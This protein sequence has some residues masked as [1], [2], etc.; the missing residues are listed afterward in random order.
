[1]AKVRQTI[2]SSTL[3]NRDIGK[4]IKAFNR[5]RLLDALS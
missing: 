5:F 2:D 3:G 4:A 1:M